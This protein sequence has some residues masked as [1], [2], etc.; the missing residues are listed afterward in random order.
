M[1]SNIRCIICNIEIIGYGYNSK[2]L[3]EG[4][5]CLYC[6]EEL[7]KPYKKKLSENNNNQ[8]KLFEI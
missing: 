5:C 1:S 6:N 3:A 8:Y 7:V 2:P 4:S